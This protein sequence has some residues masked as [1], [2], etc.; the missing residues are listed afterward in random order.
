MNPRAA[1]RATERPARHSH[2]TALRWA[3]GQQRWAAGEQ[4]AQGIKCPT[5]Q[6]SAI[7]FLL[8]SFLFSPVL[9]E[10][11]AGAGT[12]P[13]SPHCHPEQRQCTLVSRRQRMESRDSEARLH[14]THFP[15]SLL[16]L[17]ADAAEKQPTEKERPQ[18]KKLQ[19]AEH[20]HTPAAS[21]AVRGR[22]ISVANV[23]I[24]S[25]VGYLRC[26]SANFFFFASFCA[27]PSAGKRKGVCTEKVGKWQSI[28]AHFQY[29]LTTSDMRARTSW[30]VC[31]MNRLRRAHS[32]AVSRR[33]AN[34]LIKVSVCIW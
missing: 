14:C 31:S 23:E 33:R 21:V 8:L 9:P 12:S 10:P 25:K 19:K 29:A 3:E 16:S 1:Y 4:T 17:S 30:M 26:R 13:L 11:P 20:T 7:P 6:P 22:F 27:P 2:R 5:C 32:C 18:T 34:T 24:R 15:P 28:P